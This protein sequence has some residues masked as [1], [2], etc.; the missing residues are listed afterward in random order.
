[1]R[2]EYHILAGLL[3]DVFELVRQ[4]GTAGRAHAKAQADSLT[5]PFNIPIDVLG[6]FFSQ[7][8]CHH[9]FSVPSLGGK[10]AGFR[11]LL[12]I[13]S[14]ARPSNPTRPPKSRLPPVSSSGSSPA[15][16]PALPRSAYS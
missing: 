2:F 16:K 15:A 12:S 7:S 9:S 8:N 3:I 11:Q 13:A 4:A 14:R 10:T 1:M 6:R 5:A